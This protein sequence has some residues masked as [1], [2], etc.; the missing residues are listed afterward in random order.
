VTYVRNYPYTSG[1]GASGTCQFNAAYAVATVTEY[2]TINSEEG[3]YQQASTGGPVSV[4][5]A[6][7]TWQTYTGGVITTCDTTVDHCVQLAGYAGVGNAGAYWVVRNS[8]GTGKVKLLFWCNSVDWGEQ[9][10]IWI[11]IGQNLCLIGDYGTIVETL[12]R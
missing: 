5:V 8:W 3:L 2:Y 1:S 7:E 6:A 12:A 11:E 4:C 10:Y 9:G